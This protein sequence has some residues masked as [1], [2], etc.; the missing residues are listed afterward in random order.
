M[1]CPVIYGGN[2]Q[3]AQEIRAKLLQNKK[4]CFQAPNIIPLVG[5][6]DIDVAEEIIRHL[7]MNRIVDMKGLGDIIKLVD[8]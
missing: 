5:V 3:V 4:E 1:S 6:L 7:F 8:G 2:S